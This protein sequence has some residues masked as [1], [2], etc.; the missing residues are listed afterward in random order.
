V[1]KLTHAGVVES[2]DDKAQMDE[3]DSVEQVLSRGGPGVRELAEALRK[4][5][6]DVAAEATERG[7]LGW[8]TISYEAGSVFCYIAPLKDSVNLGFHRGVDLPDPQGLLQGTGKSM[9]H[10][11]IRSID[12]IDLDALTALLREA[13]ELG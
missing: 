13:A 11:K 5:V 10:V 3:H 6:R 1:G 2:D 7:H 12:E 8:G 9:R 4:L